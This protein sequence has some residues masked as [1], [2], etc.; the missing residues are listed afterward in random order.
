MKAAAVTGAT[1]IIGKEVI[2]MLKENGYCIHAL[3]R[4]KKSIV[5][6][7]KYFCGDLNDSKSL[8]PFLNKVDFLF[9]CAAEKTQ[10]KLM[11]NTNITG[12]Q[13]LFNIASDGDLK[14]FCHI[15]SAGVIGKTKKKWVD[16]TCECNPQ[17]EYERTKYASEKITTQKIPNCSTVILRPINV[18]DNE[19]PDVFGLP[20]R[21]GLKDKFQVFIKGAECAHMVHSKLVAECA[22][23]FMQKTLQKPEIFFVGLDEDESNTYK[24]IWNRVCEHSGKNYTKINW[25]LPI[26]IPFLIRNIKGLHSN[27]GNTRYSSKK[28]EKFGFKHQWSIHRIIKILIKKYC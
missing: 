8:V 17:N 28:L 16:E 3:T 12:T 24:A 22:I 27:L 11:T 20:I 9:H 25:T 19:N 6:G 5:D 21:N 10:T 7:V 18:M 2:S 26:W 23:F 1:G 13:N 14:Y 15:S 4:S